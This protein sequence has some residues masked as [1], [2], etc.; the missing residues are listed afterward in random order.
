MWV[1][2]PK[3]QSVEVYRFA[4]KADQ[5]AIVLREADT[6]ETP[7]LPDLTIRIGELFAS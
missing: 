7:L 6:L 2:S 4:E 5:P 3:T 1:V